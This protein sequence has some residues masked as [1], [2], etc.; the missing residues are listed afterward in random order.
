MTAT[1]EVLATFYGDE[2]FPIEWANE[3]EKKL[4]WWYSDLHVPYPV[5]PLYA[6]FLV[7][8]WGEMCEYMYRRFGA[9]FGKSWPDK[10]VNGYRY[11]AIVP[12]DP[13]EAAKIA[14]YFGM[15]MPTYAKEFLGW[16]RDR[17]L[18]EIKRNLAYMD[19]FP[20]DSATLPEL[21]I[22]LEE[23]RDIWERHFRIHWI[24]NL[25][26]FSTSLD[27]GAAI[28]EVIGEVDGALLGRIQI[29]IEDRN[30]DSIEALWK[31]KEKVKAS[32]ALLATFEQGETTKQIL[33]ALESTEQGRAFLKDIQAYAHEFGY[34][35]LNS[36]EFMYKLWVEDVTPIVETIKGYVASDYDFPSEYQAIKDDQAAAIAE[37][38]SL[39]PDTATEEQRAR[40]ETS[41]ELTLGIMPL[42][43][44]HHFYLD[45]GTNAR[46]HLMFLTLGRH[47]T[48]IGLLDAPDDV[49]FLEYDQ[50]RWYVSNPKTADNPE[51]YDGKTL[52]KEARRAREEAWKIR[53]VDWI[54][55][56]THW[57]L[58]EEPYKGLW[59]YPDRFFQAQEKADEPEDTIKGLSGA[60]GVAE[61]IARIVQGA[62][63]FDQ[64]KKGEIMVCIMTNPAWVVVF[65]KIAGIVCDSGGALAHPAVVAR[66]FG[67]PAVVG[68]INGT[69]RIKTGDRV[70]INGSTGVVEVLSRA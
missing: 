55:T 38:R 14:P 67:I 4:H 47:L 35:T 19:S 43:P 28:A 69:Q 66:E 49:F 9:P 27:F 56:V 48:S 39:I 65:T 30:L 10:I 12:R 16:W 33:P 20:G 45:Q 64:V 15:V 26:Q 21:M 18:P 34:K 62:D 5:C 29:S 59:G 37:L 24:L 40:L 41:L 25:A 44:D 11:T 17:Y 36:H 7:K 8:W 13:E 42:T 50:L 58:Y 57:S 54:G 68:T 61:G 60:A 70:R 22:H 52:I 46:M 63:E 3:E 2:H 1:N 51:G 32:A 31:L 23:A 6:S 53:P